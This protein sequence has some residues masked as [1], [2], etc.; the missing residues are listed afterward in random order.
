MQWGAVP[1]S[2]WRLVVLSSKIGA[3]KQKLRMLSKM[4]P[5]RSRLRFC[6]R[7]VS[8][9]I[10]Y[11]TVNLT[12]APNFSQLNHDLIT[13][14]VEKPQ[15]FRPRKCPGCVKASGKFQEKKDAAWLAH[16]PTMTYSSSDN[17]VGLTCYIGS[18]AFQRENVTVELQ[19]M[20]PT[21]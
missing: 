17:S 8:H 13:A 21:R 12:N 10:F 14:L 3:T 16:L 4:S 15:K 9:N 19:P 18:K 6:L 2:G 5:T 1:L 20:G 11:K 7:C